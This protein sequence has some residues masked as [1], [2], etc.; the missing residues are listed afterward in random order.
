MTSTEPT[1][2]DH[3]SDDILSELREALEKRRAELTNKSKQALEEISVE[4]ERGGRDTVDESTEE[5]ATSTLLRLKDREKKFLNKINGALERIDE[6]EY[7]RCLDCD[8]PIPV[9][10]LRARPTTLFCIECKEERER[11]EKRQS[12]QRPTFMDEFDF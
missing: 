7:G 8:E 11:A 6:D 2:S 5:Q 12:K 4:K 1:M 10:R 9:E 3:L